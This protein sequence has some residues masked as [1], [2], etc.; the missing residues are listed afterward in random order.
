[1]M[2]L[3]LRACYKSVV[4]VQSSQPVSTSGPGLLPSAIMFRCSATHLGTGCSVHFL[5]VS[6]ASGRSHVGIISS[7][8]IQK[9]KKPPRIELSPSAMSFRAA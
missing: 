8:L 4:T 2:V 6:Q 5:C 7:L 1:M 3:I 9:E